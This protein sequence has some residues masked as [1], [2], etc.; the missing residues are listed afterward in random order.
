M[1]AINRHI[2]RLLLASTGTIALVCIWHVVS[3]YILPTSSALAPPAKVAQALQKMWDS[4]EL[5]DSASASVKRI[6]VGFSIAVIAAIFFSV[7]AS[8]FSRLYDSVRV[9]L[10]LLSSI[11][12]IAWTPLAIMWFGIGDT[13]AVFI[14]ALGGFFPV[15]TNFYAGITRVDDHLI[16]AARTM[17]A[18]RTQIVSGVIFPAALPSFFTGMRTGLIVAWFNVIAAEL[19]GVRSGL[20][21]QIQ[22]NRTLLLSDSVIALMLVI[23]VIGLAMMQLMNLVAKL[24]TPWAI[25][26]ATRSFWIGTRRQFS[27]FLRRRAARHNSPSEMLEQQDQSAANASI[28]VPYSTRVGSD[29]GPVLVVNDLSKSF[30]DGPERLEVLRDISFRVA[31]G[32]VIAVIGPN[33][34]GKST[35]LN[36]VAGLLKAD[37]GSVRFK[38]KDVHVP[39]HE[40]TMVFQDFALFP[41]RTCSGNIE[42]AL[43]AATTGNH[44]GANRESIV[45]GLLHEAQLTGFAEAYPV[46]LSG[47]MRQRLAIARA[48]AASPELILMDEPYSAYDPLFKDESQQAMLN[49]I[50]KRSISLVIVTHDLDEAIFMADRIIVLSERPATIKEIVNVGLPQPRL[51][52]V[53]LCPEFGALHSRLRELLKQSASGLE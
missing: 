23:G 20:G 25:Q 1:L 40:R 8:R 44:T 48:L 18:S 12:P 10:E 3:V 46:E 15:F 7:V 2:R 17:G 26:D 27:R 31:A 33:G 16:N 14:V 13:P 50:A 42:F 4:G 6:A 24:S 35:L 11:P 39:G 36:I 43:R 51:N 37:I 45:K 47:G 52:D 9:G 53:R 34:S 30:G 38:G 21:Y 22:L 41:F 29:S 32:E 5:M 49:L 28:A 19:I